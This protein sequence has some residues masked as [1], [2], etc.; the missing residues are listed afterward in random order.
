[1]INIFAYGEPDAE[2]KK[3]IIDS[4]RGE[5]I[6][7]F[8]YSYIDDCDLNRLAKI[9]INQ[10]STDEKEIWRR[11]RRLLTLKA[12]D[13]ILHKHVPERGKVTAARICSEY[14]YDENPKPIDTFGRQDG[15]H[16]FR[17]D[18]I[19]EFRR[20]AVHPQLQTKLK[21][22]GSLY[23]IPDVKEFF[24]SMQVLGMPI[25]QADLVAAAEAGAILTNSVTS[26]GNTFTPPI[27]PAPQ[28][29]SDL[30]SPIKKISTIRENYLKELLKVLCNMSPDDPSRNEVLDNIF[31]TLQKFS[32]VEL[33]NMIKELF[34]KNGY[35]LIDDESDLVFEMFSERELMHDLYKTADEP[36]KIFVRLKTDDEPCNEPPNSDGN[37][38][39]LIDLTNQSDATTQGNG[40]IFISGETFANILARHGIR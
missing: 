17:V 20:D 12:G 19:F 37:I 30:N 31:E 14:F 39:I 40:V 28:Q 36:K 32:S 22:M 4:L 23:K 34:I 10:M 25:D 1:M 35:R 6:S 5:K 21:V 24:E 2:A 11:G 16:C 15:R 26:T 9:P 29:E 27:N 18:K 7:R 33:K 13:Y 8:L 38:R 3:F